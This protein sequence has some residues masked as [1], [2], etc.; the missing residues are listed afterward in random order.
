MLVTSTCVL[1]THAKAVRPFTTF[2]LIDTYVCRVFQSFIP[3]LVITKVINNINSI[4]EFNHLVI[5]YLCT[6]KYQA[7]AQ[8][9]PQYSLFLI[10]V[11][12]KLAQDD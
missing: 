4:Q 2:T 10:K 6:I 8:A 11:T 3:H 7:Y 1:V 12:L 9:Y 5:N